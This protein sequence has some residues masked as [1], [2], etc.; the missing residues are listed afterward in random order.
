MVLVAFVKNCSKLVE[1]QKANI[2]LD[3]AG[4]HC[5][6]TSVS[7][8]SRPASRPLVLKTG[9]GNRFARSWPAPIMRV[10]FGC[11]NAT[12]QQVYLLKFD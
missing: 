9:F 10:A 5:K 7:E 12:V 6:F 1:T 2:R 11:S 4:E 3:S 8:S